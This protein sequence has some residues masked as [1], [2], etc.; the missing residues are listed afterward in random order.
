MSKKNKM[1]KGYDTSPEDQLDVSFLLIGNG[2]CRLQIDTV[3]S[4][5]TE[6]NI[7]IV[8]CSLD[9]SINN[10]YPK[11]LVKF[12]PDKIRSGSCHAFNEAYKNSDG[13]YIICITDSIN[14]SND[15]YE[16]IRI[17]KDQQEEGCDLIV[18]SLTA[19]NGGSPKVIECACEAAE[20]IPQS[21]CAYPIHHFRPDIMRWPCLARETIEN[22]MQGHIFPPVFNHHYMDNWIGL[23]LF[24]KGESKSESSISVSDIKHAYNC[25]Y[26]EHDL[27]ILNRLSNKF[28]VSKNLDHKDIKYF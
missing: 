7:E 24:L 15:I 18:T 12:V 23:W 26:D 21:H 2:N 13:E 8:V 22:E 10:S 4:I 11:D 19:E 28:K 17:L 9:S 5:K 3:L 27:E 6:Y 20:V 14:I 1:E 25:K 16:V